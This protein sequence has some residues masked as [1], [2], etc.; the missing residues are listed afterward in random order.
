MVASR[1]S[2][3]TLATVRTAYEAL[4]AR[5]DKIDLKLLHNA[6]QDLERSLA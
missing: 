1:V 2:A 3:E 6:I 4:A 5:G